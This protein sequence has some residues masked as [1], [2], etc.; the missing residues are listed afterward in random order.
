M[1]ELRLSFFEFLCRTIPEG[2]LFIVAIYIF[3]GIKFNTK[4][5]LL[6][7][8]ILAVITFLIRML[9]ISYGLHIVLDIIVF[10]GIQSLII[11]IDINK[12]IKYAILTAILM[13]I[14][15][16]FNVGFL[17]LFHA[18]KME[19]ILNNP[20]LKT[21]YG[22]PSLIVFVIVLLAYKLIKSNKKEIEYV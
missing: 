4:R 21:L 22:L 19:E 20:M 18:N 9:P 3:S 17:E 14:C 2:L 15:E 11:K 12:S 13:F 5:F 6:S 1:M 16:G 8:F 10:F 7:G